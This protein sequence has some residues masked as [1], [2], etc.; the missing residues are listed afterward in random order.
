[1]VLSS[2]VP[3][4]RVGQTVLKAVF[5]CFFG[6][7]GAPDIQR[8]LFLPPHCPSGAGGACGAAVGAAL[9]FP[10]APTQ[11]DPPAGRSA[12]GGRRKVNG[13]E[14][15]FERA[16]WEGKSSQAK[17]RW[18]ESYSFHRKTYINNSIS[19]KAPALYLM[20]VWQ[21]CFWGLCE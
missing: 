18:E 1:M 6:I 20:K 16:N 21:L 11:Q 13:R 15:Q 17:E 5:G 2:M 4:L 12:C 19:T 7:F 9:G 10:P 3:P 14:S 8:G